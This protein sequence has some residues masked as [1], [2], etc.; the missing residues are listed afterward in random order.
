MMVRSHSICPD[1]IEQ[2]S[3][4]LVS[5]TSCTNKNASSN[6]ASILVL[7]KSLTVRPKIIKPQHGN[8]QDWVDTNTNRI[9]QDASSCVRRDA[10]PPRKRTN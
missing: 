1:G 6:D 4:K 8:Q 10:T 7:D 5:I 3:D 9:P 2:F